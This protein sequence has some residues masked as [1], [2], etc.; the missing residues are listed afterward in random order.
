MMWVH[1]PVAVL[2]NNSDAAEAAKKKADAAGADI[3]T[4]YMGEIAIIAL[5]VGGC[6]CLILG[7]CLVSRLQRGSTVLLLY[8]SRAWSCVLYCAIGTLLF[9]PAHKVFTLYPT[10]SNTVS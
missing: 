5:E 6:W 2:Q 10:D 9:Q 3:D 4:T 8:N 7:F 1:A